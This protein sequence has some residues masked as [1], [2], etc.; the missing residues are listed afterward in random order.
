[1][2]KVLLAPA[3]AGLVVGDV[4]VPGVMVTVPVEQSEFELVFGVRFRNASKT[5]TVEV[6]AVPATGVE[7]EGVC[8]IEFAIAGSTLMLFTVNVL[9]LMVAVM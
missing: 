6:K 1:M 3:P 9:F 2:S 8:V 5:C 4:C 7:V